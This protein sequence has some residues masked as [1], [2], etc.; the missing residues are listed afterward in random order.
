[1]ILLS[2]WK[3]PWSWS[4]T[5]SSLS[6]NITNGKKF[7]SQELLIERLLGGSLGIKLTQILPRG[8]SSLSSTQM[9]QSIR[10]WKITAFSFTLM[11]ATLETSN[12]QPFFRKAAS[13]IACLHKAGHFASR[14]LKSKGTGL[15]NC[16][17]E[18]FIKHGEGW[19]WR[20][21]QT[22][23]TSVSS[24]N[25]RSSTEFRMLWVKWDPFFWCLCM[26]DFHI[27]IGLLPIFTLLL[28]TLWKCFDLNDSE[29][30]SFKGNNIFK[31][32]F[33]TF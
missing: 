29:L 20:E 5:G 14:S 32:Y 27:Q 28:E 33:F 23:K 26:L 10:S 15:F 16:C 3:L 4:C 11:E 22:V 8:S 12:V 2:L 18:F 6:W 1:M 13:G 19:V 9:R 24:A 17:Q 30:N 21:I 25:R 7:G 31:N